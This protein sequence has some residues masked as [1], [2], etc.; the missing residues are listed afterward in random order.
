MKPDGIIKTSSIAP[1]VEEIENK[2]LLYISFEK[3]IPST[4]RGT[5]INISLDE[6]GHVKIDST[7]KQIPDPSTIYVYL[8]VTENYNVEQLPYWPHYIDMSPGQRYTYLNWL[9]NV[10]NPIDPG[11]VF[12]YY[13]GLERH[14]LMGNFE[15]ALNQII[16]LRNMHKNKSFQKYSEGALIHSCIM[17]NRL[18]LLLNLHERTEIS[19]FSN[20]QFLLAYSLKCNL[21]VQNLLQVFYKAFNLSRK[22]IKENYNLIEECTKVILLS[23]YDEESFSIKDYDISKTRTAIE[24][25]FTNYSFPEEIQNVEITNFYQCKQ[26]MTDVETIFKLSYDE[27][28]KR[29]SIERK[30]Q[31]ANK[32]DDEIKLDLMKKD[33]SRYK[34]LL[35]DKKITNE[36]FEILINFTNN[37][38]L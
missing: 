14:L 8:P 33:I 12:L 36:E 6:N 22:A 23:K 38:N 2:D 1:F 21:S 5:H 35:S 7:K 24:N 4:M 29:N 32:S 19:G 28:K 34:K 10:D 17:R 11:Y 9:R 3:D 31:K 25:R 16:R 13:Y 18:D 15:K 26:L 27:Y 37:K 20:A 30:K